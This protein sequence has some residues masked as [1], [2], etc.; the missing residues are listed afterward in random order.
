[1]AGKY[2]IIYLYT[3]ILYIVY[4]NCSFLFVNIFAASSRPLKP[5]SGSGFL[6]KACYLFCFVQ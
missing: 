4:V 1:M 6:L 3:Y 2:L 5:G